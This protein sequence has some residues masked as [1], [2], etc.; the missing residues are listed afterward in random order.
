MPPPELKDGQLPT[1]VFDITLLETGTVYAADNFQGDQ[2]VTVV[3]RKNFIGLPSAQKFIRS[4]LDGSADLQLATEST[5]IPGVGMAFVADFDG[6]GTAEPW[7]IQKPGK[8]FEAEGETKLKCGISAAVNPVIYGSAGKT[9]AELYAGISFVEDALITPFTLAAHLPAG[10]ALVA[11][12]WA[13]AGLPSGLSI[14]ATTGVVS[15]TPTTV[16]VSYVKITVDAKR[17][18]VRN[19]ALVTQTLRGVREFVITITAP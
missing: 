17:E 14:D 10:A 3:R 5:A 9:T 1:G 15:G 13:H 19:G 16:G 12:T 6:D 18:I 4:F 7:L 2:D 11:A 8:T